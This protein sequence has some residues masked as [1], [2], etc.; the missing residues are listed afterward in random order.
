MRSELTLRRRRGRRVAAVPA[1]DPQLLAH[2]PGLAQVRQDFRRH[3]FGQVQDRMVV[4]DVDAAD[5]AALQPGLV[6]DRPDDIARLHAVGMANLDP[7][8]LHARLGRGARRLGCPCRARAVTGVEGR[9]RMRR[10]GLLA[11]V[12]HARPPR[13]RSATLRA[14][15]RLGAR[16]Q[17]QRRIALQQPRQRRGDLAGAHIVLAGIAVHQF[18]VRR[19]VASFQRPGDLLEETRHAAVV[20]R[21]HAGQAHLLDRLSG[22]ALDRAQ[23]A[24]LARGH[25]QDRLAAAP[26]PAGAADPVHVALGVV[27]NVVVEH[28]ADA[29]HVQ[30]ARGHVGGHQ[31]IQLA[32]LELGDGAF[33]LLLL[34]VAVDRR[35]G[36]P[37]RLQLAGQLLGGGLGAGEHDH[38]VE[39][40]GFENAGQRIELVQATDEPVALADVGRRGGPGGDVD[41]GRITQV[42]LGDAP[43]RRRHGRREQRHLARGRGLLQHRLDIVDEA[44]AQHL[45]GLVQHQR[46]QPGQVQ[47]AALQMVD[48]PARGPDHHVHAAAQ[49]MQLRPIALAAVDR[50]HLEAGQP[51]RVALE[52]LGHLDRQLAGRRQHQRLRLVPGQVQAR[53]HRQGEGG[54]L[55]GAGLGG[56]QHVAAGQQCRDGGGLDRRRRFIADLGQGGQ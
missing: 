16:F 28:V 56:A 39:R 24:A 55:A 45:V 29:L 49:R 27:G 17:Q 38:R 43:D 13:R 14:R 26:G 51:R 21:L 23:H 6:G 52:R 33:A 47:G 8:G 4:V 37:A 3:A 40:L 32:V 31:H 11:L 54:G 15:R 36:H 1:A 50:Q 18:P 42:G 22:G 48:H 35:S 19:Q 7:E 9:R 10:E 30:P 20:D 5:V 53:Q 25:E 44:H 41:L 34:H 46:A 12:V 2:H